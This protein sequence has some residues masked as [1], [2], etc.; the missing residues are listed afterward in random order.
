MSAYFISKYLFIYLR[1][2]NEWKGDSEAETEERFYYRENYLRG[3]SSTKR[4]S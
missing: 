1:F 3:F 4:T 2:V